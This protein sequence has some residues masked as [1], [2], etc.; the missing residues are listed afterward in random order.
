MP[1]GL[2]HG[3]AALAAGGGRRVVPRQP[4]AAIAAA[5]A[6][7]VPIL[8]GTNRD[9]WKLFTLFDAKARRLDDAGLRRRLAR[10]LPEA[11][12]DER[13]HALP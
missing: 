13:A 11:G 2:A 1:L 4:L 8:A 9:E 3:T 5:S 6:R 7:D 12:G 10:I